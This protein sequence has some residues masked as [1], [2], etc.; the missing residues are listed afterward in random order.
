MSG[1]LFQ[2]TPQ[3]ATSYVT[4]T[5][6]MPK[7]LQDAI[8]NQIQVA[9]NVANRPYT[10]YTGDMVADL[11]PL[12]QQAY[13][14][15]QQNVGA[16]LPDMSFATSGMKNISQDTTAPELQAAQNPYLQPAL[17]GYNLGAG[18]GY[19]AQAGGMN[20]PGAAQPLMAKAETTTGQSLAERALTAANPYL[21]AAGQTSASQVGQYMSP[22]QQGVLDAIAKQGVVVT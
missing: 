9:T 22:Y 16:Y 21:T 12:Q 11:T 1:S 15:T 14:Q 8:Y 13:Q 7:W 6:E 19:F 18:Q 5:Q 17:S 4:T 2:G 10:P 20:I 3:A